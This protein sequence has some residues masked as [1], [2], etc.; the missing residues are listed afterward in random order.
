V[1][2]AYVEIIKNYLK[3]LFMLEV[4]LGDEVETIY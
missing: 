3:N 4:F 1:D 2:T